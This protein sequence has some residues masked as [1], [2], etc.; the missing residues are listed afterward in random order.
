MPRSEPLPVSCLSVPSQDVL[1][2]IRQTIDIVG[3]RIYGGHV[4]MA[5]G[6]V[7][8]YDESIVAY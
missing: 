2:A 6:T 7:S 8:K 1:I 5:G 3:I 4:L